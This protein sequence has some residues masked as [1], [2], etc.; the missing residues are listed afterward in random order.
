M[1]VIGAEA[2]YGS[3]L[4]VFH[5]VKGRN[6]DTFNLGGLF[7]EFTAAPALF[8]IF[9]IAVHQFEINRLSLTDIEHV[10]EIGQ[11]LRIIGAGAASD[12]NGITLRPVRRV[13]RNLC[14]IQNLQNVRV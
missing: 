1:A 4:M 3:V 9:F 8:L 11:G 5:I 12:D 6:I 2:F 7:Q 10:E 14:Q 13:K